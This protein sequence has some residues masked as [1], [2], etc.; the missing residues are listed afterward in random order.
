MSTDLITSLHRH[1]GFSE[2]RPGQAEAIQHLLDSQNVLVVMPTGSGKSLIYQ[3][4]SFH[5]PGLTL[6]LSPLIAL[7]KDQVD[8]LA[9]GKYRLVYIAPERLL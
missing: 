8:S 1:F 4:A 9:R 7:M 2:F 5:L 6:V 3:L